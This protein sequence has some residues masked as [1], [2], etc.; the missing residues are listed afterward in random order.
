MGLTASGNYQE[1]LI[2]D[3]EHPIAL[4][5]FVFDILTYIANLGVLVQVT[6]HHWGKQ[7]RI[8]QSACCTAILCRIFYMA[9]AYFEAPPIYNFIYLFLEYLTLT[10][11][12]MVELETLK[13][14]SGLA[15]MMSRKS[16]SPT[17]VTRIQIAT[18][19]IYGL[20]CLTGQIVL[21]FHLG[22][23]EFSRTSIFY[24]WYL[25]GGL[26][27]AFYLAMLVMGCSI[28][29]LYI[30]TKLLKSLSGVSRAIAKAKSGLQTLVWLVV[31]YAFMILSA[32]GVYSLGLCYPVYQMT[33][34]IMNIGVCLAS[35]LP[36][37][38][39]LIAYNTKHMLDVSLKNAF[40]M[41]SVKEHP[42]PEHQ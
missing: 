10:C 22:D 35:M 7:W 33:F 21:L 30:L 36:I 15:H 39:F 11:F 29:Q 6:R 25:Y 3:T 13:K 19:V 1:V 31:M 5:S 20:S 34:L 27:H 42:F 12:A 38:L 26:L 37:P 8:L 18:W 41:T 40:Q 28:Y 4:L 23:T 14:F 16:L 17:N 24:N 32:F 9:N 2:V